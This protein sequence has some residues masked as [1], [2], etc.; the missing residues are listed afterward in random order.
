M[1]Q[2]MTVMVETYQK[3]IHDM[4]SAQDQRLADMAQSQEKNM[5]RIQELMQQGNSGATERAP[6]R[7]GPNPPLTPIYED[8]PVEEESTVA[9]CGHNWRKAAVADVAAAA[10]HGG[11]STRRPHERKHERGGGSLPPPSQPPRS[12]PELPT[13]IGAGAPPI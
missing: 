2:R 5:T 9:S 8:H 11:A 4:R 7:H 3:A 10:T 13:P 1:E 6:E 12:W